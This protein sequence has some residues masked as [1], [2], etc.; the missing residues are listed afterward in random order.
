MANLRGELRNAVVCCFQ[1]GTKKREY[2]QKYGRDMDSKIFSYG[3][4]KALLDRAG[5]LATFVQKK[6]PGDPACE[7]NK[8]STHSGI[9]AGETGNRMYEGNNKYL[10]C[11]NKKIGEML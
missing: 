9:F 11:T 1:E 2:K 6:H 10:S 8:K 3:S 4:K 7:R 5:E